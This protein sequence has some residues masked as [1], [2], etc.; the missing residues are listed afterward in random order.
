M[1]F[2]VEIHY[3]PL[4]PDVFFFV[5]YVTVLCEPSCDADPSIGFLEIRLYVPVDF[6]HNDLSIHHFSILSNLFSVE[7]HL[8]YLVIYVTKKR[9]WKSRGDWNVFLSWSR[10]CVACIKNN[11]IRGRVSSL[12]LFCKLPCNPKKVFKMSVFIKNISIYNRIQFLATLYPT[13]LENLVVEVGTRHSHQILLLVP[14][15]T[16]PN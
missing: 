12:Q 3:N 16:I 13:S 8:R 1:V 7:N 9:L 11:A 6:I 10:G 4:N 5:I 14:I 15:V 2:V